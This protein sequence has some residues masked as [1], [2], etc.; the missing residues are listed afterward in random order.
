[1]VDPARAVVDASVAVKWHLKDEE[2]SQESALL[3]TR[4][5]Q[6]QLELIAPFHI[7][8]EVASA[9]SV[10]TL[11][12][13][14]RLSQAEGR[15][16]IEEFLAL[17]ISLIHDDRLILEAYPI[18]HRHRCAFYDAL[19]LALAQRLSIPLVIADRR[20]HQRVGHLP[21]VVW[22]GDY[23]SEPESG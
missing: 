19:Y 13:Q 16:A 21:D 15:D 20:L 9:V 1:M 22:I 14:P 17:G 2:Y 23:S 8:Y 7:A 4:F 3:L 10:A 5:A 18:V 12:Q 11:G 6:G